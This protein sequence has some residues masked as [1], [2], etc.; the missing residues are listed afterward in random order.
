MEI[1]TLKYVLLTMC[2][3]SLMLKAISHKAVNMN[4]TYCML[5]HVQNHIRSAMTR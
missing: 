4:P 2:L 3:S 5:L 1:T